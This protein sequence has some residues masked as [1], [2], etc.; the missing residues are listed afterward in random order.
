PYND[1]WI[2]DFGPIF[3]KRDS[4]S[5]PIAMG[6]LSDPE[7][8]PPLICHDF[9]FNGWGGKYETRDLDDA[10][11]QHIAEHLK[12]P[13]WTNPLVL[14]G[15]SIDVNGA[16]TVMTTEQCL[17]NPNRNPHLTKAQ[18]EHELCKTLGVRHVI[19]LPGGIIGDD[20]DGHID[21]IA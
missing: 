1:S 17:L 3:V 8:L 19:W 18:I 14:E 5:P 20:T 13:V 2:R 15:G 7:N 12:I 9:H 4:Q 16:G 11:P 10:V 6:G 21:D